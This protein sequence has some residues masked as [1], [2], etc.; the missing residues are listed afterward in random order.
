VEHENLSFHA[1]G[2]AQVEILRGQIPKESSGAEEPV[3]V[4]NVL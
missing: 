3:V 4:M 2:K 1:K